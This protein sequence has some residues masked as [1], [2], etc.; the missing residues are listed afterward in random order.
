MLQYMIAVHACNWQYVTVEH[1]AALLWPLML[2]QVH[3]MHEA[4]AI[5]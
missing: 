5:G 3:N 1:N 2:W 4:A